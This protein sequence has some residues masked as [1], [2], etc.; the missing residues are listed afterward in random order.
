MNHWQVQATARRKIRSRNDI[1]GLLENCHRRK[2]KNKKTQPVNRKQFGIF[3]KSLTFKVKLNNDNANES[4][5]NDSPKSNGQIVAMQKPINRNKNAKQRPARGKK[6]GPSAGRNRMQEFH[7]EDFIDDNA[8]T[9]DKNKQGKQM[10]NDSTAA[11]DGHEINQCETL[12]SKPSAVQNKETPTDQNVQEDQNK[13]NF[14]HFDDD[15][16]VD[17]SGISVDFTI[18]TLDVT[19]R[20]SNTMRPFDSLHTEHNLSPTPQKLASSIDFNVFDSQIGATVCQPSANFRSDF[21]QST[22]NGNNSTF[23]KNVSDESKQSGW[24]LNTPNFFRKDFRAAAETSFANERTK[25]SIETVGLASITEETNE[26]DLNEFPS[27]SVS[28]QKSSSTSRCDSYN[29]MCQKVYSDAST[30]QDFYSSQQSVSSDELV[31]FNASEDST[32]S[33]KNTTFNGFDG[34]SKMKPFTLGMVIE[35][36]CLSARRAYERIFGGRAQRQEIANNRGNRA[37]RS[38]LPAQTSMPSSTLFG[39]NALKKPIRLIFLS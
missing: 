26:G 27:F 7:V 25:N 2:P 37:K 17:F 12:P 31:T 5:E 38:Q 9:N 19:A 3:A 21:D 10:G 16:Q 1:M 36:K 14:M 29:P 18:G 20:K 32:A 8:A 4:I 13:N 11:N 35:R 22:F 28:T 34:P 23:R 15:N 24:S 6:C 39:T 30:N 33:D